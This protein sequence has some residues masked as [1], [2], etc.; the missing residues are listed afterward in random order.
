MGNSYCKKDYSKGEV[1]LVEITQRRLQKMKNNVA[2]ISFYY[3]VHK[4]WKKIVF[5]VVIRREETTDLCF[6]LSAKN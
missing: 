3:L 6:F 2:M 4:I 1:N 5:Y